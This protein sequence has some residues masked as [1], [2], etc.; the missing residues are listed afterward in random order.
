[1]IKKWF[2]IIAAGSSKTLESV[3]SLLIELGSPSI[4]ESDENGKKILKA[5]IPIDSSLNAKINLLKNRLKKYEWTYQG[6]MF[7]DKDWLNKWKRYIKPVRISNRLTIKPT[8]EKISSKKGQIIVEIDPGM[9]FGTGS[10][11]STMMCLKAADRLSAL[12]KGNN[13]LDVGTGSG[14]LAITSAKLGAKKVVGIDIDAEAVKVAR[15]N[16][17]LNRVTDRV[18]IYTRPLEKIKGRFSVIFANIIAEELITIANLLK[19]R[20]M[21]N[22]SLILS[23]ILKE[24]AGEVGDAYKGLGLKLFKTYKKGEWVCLIFK[25]TI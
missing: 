9:A 20:L 22:G 11:A 16:I 12:I 7:K 18:I 3:T 23:G 24:M 15:K 2:E 10:H 19:A 21:N 13:I 6:S 25:K 14:I 17:R 4:L 1:M 5:Y 8:W